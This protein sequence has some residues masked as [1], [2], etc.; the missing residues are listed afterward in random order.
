MNNLW[1]DTNVLLRFITGD[2]PEMARKALSLFRR[3]EAGEVSLC[4][5]VL[6]MAE[7][8]WTLTSFYRYSKQEVSDVLIP[9]INADGIL[10]EEPELLLEAL[11]QMTA[12]N[13]DFVD[14]YLAAAARRRGEPVCS[15]DEDFKRLQV[16]LIPP[17]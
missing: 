15:F 8:V 13:I 14:A 9:L 17:E 3:A 6:V 4:L 2:P 5:S 12:Q 16:T 11:T 1:L 10:A 7:A